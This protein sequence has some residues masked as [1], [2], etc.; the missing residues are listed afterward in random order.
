[1]SVGL[2]LHP[3]GIHERVSSFDFEGAFGRAD[4]DFG[5]DEGSVRDRSRAFDLGER[6][7]RSTGND[8]WEFDPGRRLAKINPVSRVEP[9]LVHLGRKIRLDV[10]PGLA[11]ESPPF[12]ARSRGPFVPEGTRSIVLRDG[13]MVCYR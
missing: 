10:L 9:V 6:T 11:T 2:D 12:I 13:V 3:G 4:R 1:S 7:N 8:V 5:A